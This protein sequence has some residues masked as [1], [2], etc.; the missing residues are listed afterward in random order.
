MRKYICI[1]VVQRMCVALLAIGVVCTSAFARDDASA[2]L[3]NG[4]QLTILREELARERAHL[5]QLQHPAE[6]RDPGQQT[7]PAS[8]DFANAAAVRRSEDDIAALEREILRA[9]TKTPTTSTSKGTVAGMNAA[10]S[11]STTIG[12]PGWWDV[13]R[14]PPLATRHRPVSPYAP[15]APEFARPRETNIP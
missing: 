12:P 14:R 11:S 15:V 4:E 9:S 7:S 1:A 2:G 10:L 8:I 3:G 5:L 6:P 13:Y